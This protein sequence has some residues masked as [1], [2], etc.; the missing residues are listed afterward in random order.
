MA[1][2]VYVSV[3]IATPFNLVNLARSRDLLNYHTWVFISE[4]ARS[5]RKNNRVRSEYCTLW[6][7][8]SQEI[9]FL[10]YCIAFRL[11]PLSFSPPMSAPFTFPKAFFFSFHK[12]VT[13]LTFIQR[14]PCIFH[15]PTAELLLLVGKVSS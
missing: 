7:S 1:P 15:I 13:V 9:A 8:F 11:Y 4:L 12:F 10:F 5:C 14:L 6:K 2:R 3:K